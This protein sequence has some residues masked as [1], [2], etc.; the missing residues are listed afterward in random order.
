[1]L[2]I[3]SISLTIRAE[4]ETIDWS[5][6]VDFDQLR[7]EFSIR[8]D[9]VTI[10][11]NDKLKKQVR[12]IW[13]EERW[14]EIIKIIG[15][16][17]NNC[18]IDISYHHT[19]ENILRALGKDT[20]ADHHLRWANGLAGSIIKTGDGKTPQTAYKTILLGEGLKILEYLELERMASEPIEH[21]GR[22]IGKFYAID[23]VENIKIIYFDISKYIDISSIKEGKSTDWSKE[24]NFDDIRDKFIGKNI[25]HRCSPLR[26]DPK[27]LHDFFRK[28]NNWKELVNILLTRLEICPVDMRS[29]YKI[30]FALNNLERDEEATQHKGWLQGLINSIIKSGDGKTPETAYRV[31]SVSEEYDFMWV[32]ALQ[33]SS[34]AY[35]STEYGMMD[36]FEVTDEDGKKEEIYYSLK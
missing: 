7:Q 19:L 36:L 32:M 11:N 6:D 31:I 18:P 26:G 16:I 33:P 30:V 22:A 20:S 28:E 17:L 14:D 21:D 34:Q 24:V 23:K 27:K 1:M 3:C 13:E 4:Q 2:T 12:Q 9:L 5:A 10:C 35:V 8:N 29:H 15:S 25:I